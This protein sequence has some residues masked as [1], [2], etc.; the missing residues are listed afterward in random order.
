MNEKVETTVLELPRW[1]P[2][3]GTRKIERKLDMNE[4]TPEL[5]HAAINV[6]FR[7]TTSNSSAQTDG[8]EE[9]RKVEAA[10]A[11]KLVKWD[12]NALQQGVKL[13]KSARREAE[14]DLLTRM[15]IGAGIA[16][17]E[18]KKRARKKTARYDFFLLKLVQRTGKPDTPEASVR[19]FMERNKDKFEEK[20]D[21]EEAE[22]Q[23][24]RERE[25]KLRE[26]VKGD[27]WD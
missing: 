9:K 20:L 7:I 2:V 15:F 16:E 24:R 17:G 14:E 8:L 10:T 11:D 5:L 13:P 18:A 3:V 23:A 21:K 12:W 26:E 19:A 4:C 22:V 25:A 6:W 27:D 1:L